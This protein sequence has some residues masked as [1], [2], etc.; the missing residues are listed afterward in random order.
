MKNN[1]QIPLLLGF[2]G[3]LAAISVYFFIYQPYMDKTVSLEA[4]NQV[5][6]E[7]VQ[8]YQEIADNEIFYQEAIATMQAET[9][10]LVS[11]YAA[12]LTREDQIMY[13][14]NMENRFYRDLYVNYMMFGSDAEIVYTSPVQTVA[15]TETQTADEIFVE[16]VPADD[17]MKM[18]QNNTKIGFEVSYEGMKEILDYINELGTRKNL[19]NLSLSF[20]STSGM[21]SG[22]YSMDQY[23]LTG[24]DAIYS[25]SNIPAMIHGV[26][27]IFGTVDVDIQNAD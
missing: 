20:D 17:G 19:T 2:L 12:G 14:A 6:R 10:D 26:E 16:P 8:K 9:R 21:L 4:D 25:Q 15:S 23:Y 18:F 7:S 27:N 5:L 22:S 13:V 3:V 24:T 1:N 11:L